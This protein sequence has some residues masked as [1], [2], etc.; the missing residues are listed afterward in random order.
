MNYSLHDAV[1]NL[2]AI[3]IVGSYLLVQIRKMSATS[4]AYTLVNGLGALLIMISLC[5]DFNMSAF[6]V[7]SF[8]LLISLVGLG[9]IYLDRRQGLAG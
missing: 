1:G 5:F 3:L 2:G 9:R 7:E 4:L 8:W 6:V